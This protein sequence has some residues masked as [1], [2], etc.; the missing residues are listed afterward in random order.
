[1]LQ[2]LE[3]YEPAMESMLDINV[4]FEK[5]DFILKSEREVARKYLKES[6]AA[7]QID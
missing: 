2:L 6:L 4:D 3:R 5:S 7:C 1:M